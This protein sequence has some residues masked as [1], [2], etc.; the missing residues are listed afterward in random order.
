MRY[1]Q[2]GAMSRQERLP[3][4]CANHLRGIPGW[5]L[6]W[7]MKWCRREMRTRCPAFHNLRE[8]K[9]LIYK[10]LKF[11]NIYNWGGK[12]NDAGLAAGLRLVAKVSLVCIWLAFIIVIYVL[13]SAKVQRFFE[14]TKCLADF[15]CPIKWKLQIA[16]CKLVFLYVSVCITPKGAYG[17]LYYRYIKL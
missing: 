13:Q 9:V 3:T 6:S 10:E 16:N 14:T 1:R 11:L 15:F 7:W 2:W 5:R 17:L 4:R 8:W 12:T